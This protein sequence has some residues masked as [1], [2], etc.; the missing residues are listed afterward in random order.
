[1]IRAAAIACLALAGCGDSSTSSDGAVDRPG[2]GD[3]LCGQCPWD[4]SGLDLAQPPDFASADLGASR[5][6]TVADLATLA[7]S[8]PAAD[9]NDQVPDDAALQACFDAGGTVVLAPGNPGYLIATG[10]TVSKDGT[11][12]T[13]SSAP[14]RATLLAAPSLAAPILQMTGRTGVQISFVTFDG[15][16]PNRTG[17]A[18]CMGYRIFGTNVSLENSTSFSF[19]DNKSTRAMCGSALQVHGTGFELARNEIVDNGHATEAK[20]APE[21]WSDGITLGECVQ[22][23]VHDNTI[24][25]AT[26]VAIVDGGGAGC[27]IL[28]NTI[29][30]VQRHAFA[31]IALHVFTAEGNGDHTGSK[32]AG[33]SI[34]GGGRLAFALS[35]GMHPWAPTVTAKNGTVSGNSAKGA[36]VNLQVDGV[37]G[38]TVMG[39]QL[40]ATG[41]TPRCGGAPAAYTVAHATNATLDAGPLARIYDSCIP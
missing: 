24:T 32:V 36:V 35:V 39:N 19:D 10:L 7:P 16:R 20:D 34:D 23:M 6:L 5:D 33:N 8:C 21:P 30:Q 3:Y 11:I 15:N 26:D 41:G 37:D 40:G 31:G 28:N 14:T 27:Q 17:V 18:T 38:T 2:G 13:S 12:V 9:P 29:S 1:V 22:G 4:A 25:D